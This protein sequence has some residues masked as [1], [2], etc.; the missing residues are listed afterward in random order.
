MMINLF[1]ENKNV[2]IVFLLITLYSTSICYQCP[3]FIVKFLGLERHDVCIYFIDKHIPFIDWFIIYYVYYYL[4]VFVFGMIIMLSN[5][6]IFLKYVTNILLSCTAGFIIFIIFPTYFGFKHNSLNFPLFFKMGK[7][8]D[9]ECNA[10]PSFHVLK[11][12]L[13]FRYFLKLNID[14]MTKI[15]FTIVTILMCLSTV[16]IKVHGFIDIPSAILLAEFNIYLAN[17]YRLYDLFRNQLTK[18]KLEF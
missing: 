11:S 6:E 18:I 12:Y 2:F 5:K 4:H 15:L 17:K 14:V 8:V 10:F 13:V 7:V 9:I 3:I 16:F 1:K